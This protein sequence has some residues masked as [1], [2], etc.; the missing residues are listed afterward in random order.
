MLRAE[1]AHGVNLKEAIVSKVKP[2]INIPLSILG[3][4]FSR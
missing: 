2:E 1:L 3:G 4:G